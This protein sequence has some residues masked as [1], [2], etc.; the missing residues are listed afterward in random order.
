MPT[1]LKF[2]DRFFRIHH[3]KM[4]ELYERVGRRQFAFLTRE[5]HSS[6]WSNSV[7]QWIIDIRIVETDKGVHI[8][9]RSLKDVELAEKWEK[10]FVG[11]LD[12]E[13]M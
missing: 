13:F 9:P 3:D 6:V 12:N 5:T 8:V 1:S 7:T 2:P 10:I 4:K 11:C